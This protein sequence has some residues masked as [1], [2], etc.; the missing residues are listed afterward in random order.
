MTR[1]GELQ[2]PVDIP[3]MRHTPAQ[4]SREVAS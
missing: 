3:V 2:M 4:L 1:E